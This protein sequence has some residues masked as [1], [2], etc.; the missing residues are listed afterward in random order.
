MLDEEHAGDARFCRQA[1][2]GQLSGDR[3]H[4]ARDLGGRGRGSGK[5]HGGDERGVSREG[6]KA[7]HCERRLSSYSAIMDADHFREEL[8]R[9]ADSEIVE[10]Y[11]LS[12]GARHLSNDDIEYIQKVV[13]ASYGTSLS[14]VVVF[15]TGSAKLGFTTVDKKLKDGSMRP[16][17]APFDI[18]SDIDV[19][20]ISP[21]IFQRIWVELANYSAR[22]AYFPW[23]ADRLGDYL[24]CGWLRPDHFPRV[25][26]L[27]QTN[28]W[29]PT[30]ERLSKSSR[31]RRRKVRG[32]LFHSIE[33]LQ[34]YLERV[35]RISRRQEEA[36]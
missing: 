20:V 9:I 4:Q 35:V 29:W 25:T 31:Y 15:I 34:I 16:R 10:K 24:I 1:E 26:H 8:G 28:E 2:L 17:Y 5:G 7:L 27:Y 11:Y 21:K 22:K 3:E 6:G 33:H 23:R 18:A 12:E 32:G 30:F 19:A 13:A 14:E 36:A